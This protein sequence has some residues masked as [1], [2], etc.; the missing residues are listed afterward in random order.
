M[1]KKKIIPP[2]VGTYCPN[3][4]NEPL[5]MAWMPDGGRVRKEQP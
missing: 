3:P 2:G 1:G 5:Q 4:K